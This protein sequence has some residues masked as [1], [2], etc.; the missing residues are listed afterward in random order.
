MRLK[1]SLSIAELI[2]MNRLAPEELT[3]MEIE[4]KIRAVIT[5]L[6]R[7][8]QITCEENA[9]KTQEVSTRV[10][11]ICLQLKHFDSLLM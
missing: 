2:E 9:E 11:G 3:E 1:K 5:E 6:I 7:Q 10:D 8:S 4:N